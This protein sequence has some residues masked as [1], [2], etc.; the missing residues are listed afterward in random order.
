MHMSSPDV[1]LPMSADEILPSAAPGFG[2]AGPAT[3]H[4]PRLHQTRGDAG[5]RPTG[6]QTF[7]V[8]PVTLSVARNSAQALLV[9][10]DVVAACAA[11]ATANTVNATVKN[12]SQWR[13]MCVSPNVSG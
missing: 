8:A 2:V 5:T 6:R 11:L 7:A 10:P 9:A 12:A 13:C 3:R 1:C 4:L